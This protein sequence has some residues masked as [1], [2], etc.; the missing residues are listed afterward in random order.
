MKITCLRVIST[1]VMVQDPPHSA[2]RRSVSRHSVLD[3]SFTFQ[4]VLLFRRLTAALHVLA[5]RFFDA[6]LVAY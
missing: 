1:N 3:L 4:V 5:K 2:L 6:Q